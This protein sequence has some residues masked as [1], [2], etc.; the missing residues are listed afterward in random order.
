MSRK[1]K[2]SRIANYPGK[3]K[4][5]F[6]PS[7]PFLPQR[8]D[9]NLYLQNK[10]AKKNQTH[11]AFYDKVWAKDDAFWKL[12]TPGTEWNCKC[13]VEETDEPVTDNSQVPVP[14]PNDEDYKKN[15]QGIEGN[16][17][18]TGEIFTNNASYIR[19]YRNKQKR[20]IEDWAGDKLL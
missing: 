15:I 13:D 11:T 6:Y 2:K 12:N 20:K 18:K 19:A 8:Y 1:N 3:S 16:P 10:F 4:W 14:D 17:A 5:G 7:Q 9:K